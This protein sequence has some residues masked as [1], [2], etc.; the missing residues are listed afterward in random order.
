[1]K[2]AARITVHCVIRNEEYWIWYAIQ[3]ILPYVDKI[4]IFDTGSTDRTVEII[5]TFKSKKI[6]F[7]QKGVVDAIGLSRLRQEMLELTKTDWILILDGDE[8]WYRDGI[9][10]LLEKVNTAPKSV[11]GILVGMWMCYGDIFHYWDKAEKLHNPQA[12]MDMTGYVCIRAFRNFPDLQCKNAYPHEGYWE[13]NGIHISHWPTY[14]L[15][16]LKNRLLHLSYLPR[17][18]HRFNDERVLFRRL[19]T[20]YRRGTPFPKDFRYPEVFYIKR[21]ELIASPWRRV[22]MFGFILTL[23]S[24]LLKRRKNYGQ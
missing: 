12:P 16:S 13:K 3:S 21:P 19:K 1:M 14:R 22:S 2:K 18:P 6:H 20:V 8:I 11:S 7:Q 23:R 10:E 5:Q 4:L 9:K 15:R 24:W 17:T